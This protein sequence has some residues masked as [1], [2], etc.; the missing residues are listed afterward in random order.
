MRNGGFF[1]AVHLPARSQ[2]T[3]IGTSGC[4]ACSAGAPV[5]VLKE[6]TGP[7]HAPRFVVEARIEGL[8]PVTGE[9]GSK[10]QAEQAAAERLLAIVL[11][12]KSAP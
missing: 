1:G 3:S 7:D 6:R 2:V 5:Y 4:W 8:A 12:E 9:G 10:R 11:P